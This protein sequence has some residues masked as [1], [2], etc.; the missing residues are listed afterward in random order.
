MWVG[1]VSKSGENILLPREG[2]ARRPQVIIKPEGEEMRS[3]S[4]LDK[5]RGLSWE[6][7][8]GKKGGLD[9]HTHTCRHPCGIM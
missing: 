6:P 7:I 8:P 4:E 1:V 9:A 3:V 2:T 5:V